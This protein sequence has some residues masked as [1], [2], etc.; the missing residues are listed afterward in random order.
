MSLRDKVRIIARGAFLHD[1]GK[2]A[3]PDAILSKPGPLTPA[4]IRKVQEHC[5]ARISDAAEDPV[6]S[7]SRRD[8]I[9]SS[10]TLRWHRISAEIKGRPKFLWGQESSLLPIPWTRLPPTALTGPPKICKPPGPKFRSWSGKQFD[11]EIVEVFLDI[12]SE[13]WTELRR[14]IDSQVRGVT[15]DKAGNSS[16]RLTH[17]P[18]SVHAA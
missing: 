9:H 18:P 11:P 13:V 1:I 6:P 10:G 2:M 5:H 15:P 8:R 7:G 17:P 4:E 3:I 16:Q 14:E 12:P